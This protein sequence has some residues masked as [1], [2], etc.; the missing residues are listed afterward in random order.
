MHAA[1][2]SDLT[3]PDPVP[4]SSGSVGIPSIAFAAIPR[5]PLD[6]AAALVETLLPRRRAS[7]RRRARRGAER[8]TPSTARRRPDGAAL[9]AL[10]RPARAARRL[11]HRPVRADASRDGRLYGRGAADDKSGIVA[12]L[13]ALRALDGDA[14]GARE[15][16]D[17][18]LGGE[19]PPALLEVVDRD[20]DLLRADV[21]VIADGGNWKLGE[22]TLC[23]TLRGH[24]KLTVTL[25]TLEGALHSGQ[26]GGAAPDALLA[27]TRLLATLHDD[28]GS[29][30]VEGLAGRRLGRRRPA[31]GRLPSP[32]RRARRRAA[33]RRRAASPTACGRATRSPC[34]ASTRPPSR[35]PATSSSRPRAPRSRCASRRAPTRRRSMDAVERHLRG[36]RAVGRAARDRGRAGVDARSRSAPTRPPRARW[37]PPTA[38]RSRVMGSGGSIPLVARLAEAYPDAAIVLWGAQDSDRRGSTPP[39]SPSTSTSWRRSRSPRRCF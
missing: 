37:R 17:R 15:G 6:E 14:A 20:P 7:L 25:R 39:T 33:G 13:A 10:R 4:T 24:G 3:R 26:F 2:P 16:A 19:R 38:S 36:A 22:P 5:E 30:A 34:S 21:M 18:G 27:L 32:G 29:V 9:R 12:H 8:A 23:T 28:D 1:A 11:G 35:A 31:R